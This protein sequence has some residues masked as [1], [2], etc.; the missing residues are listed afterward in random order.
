MRSSSQMQH[1]TTGWSLG[2]ADCLTYVPVQLWLMWAGRCLK[3]AP[4]RLCRH[5]SRGHVSASPTHSVEMEARRRPRH[6]DGVRDAAVA[7]K[8]YPAIRWR[9]SHGTVDARAPPPALSIAID[10]RLVDHHSKAHDDCFMHGLVDPI[11]DGERDDILSTNAECGLDLWV[12]SGIYVAFQARVVALPIR[13]WV[14]SRQ[15]FRQLG[16]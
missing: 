6:G 1:V 13:V 15:V 10:R 2:P 16:L 11:L 14:L 5:R 3:G 12:F 7:Y 9:R 8:S 4:P